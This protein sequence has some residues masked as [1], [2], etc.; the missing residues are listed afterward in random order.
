MFSYR[1]LEERI[2][3]DHPLRKLRVLVDVVLL[4]LHEDFEKL[5]KKAGRASI[6]PGALV[7]SKFITDAVQ[8][9]I[10]TAIGATLGVQPAVPLVCWV[11]P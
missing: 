4:Q 6:P 9:Q 10:G 2:P 8:P 3:Q 5:Y 1:T 11:E 7:A